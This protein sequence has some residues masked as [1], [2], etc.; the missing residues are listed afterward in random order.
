MQ[1]YVKRT[2]DGSTLSRIVRSWVEARSDRK[3]SWRCFR[4]ALLS[5]FEDVQ[6]GTTPEGIH[7][8]SMA[9]TVDIIQRCFTGIEMRDNM[10]WFNPALPAELN[11][12]K[13]R[14]YFQGHWLNFYTDRQQCKIILEDGAKDAVKIG[15]INQVYELFKYQ[16]KVFD[17]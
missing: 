15:F 6:G 4:K 17:I 12:M 10:L 1:Y 11:S 13:F 16:E 9:G 2:S 3:C 7:L 14:I 8:G 5:D